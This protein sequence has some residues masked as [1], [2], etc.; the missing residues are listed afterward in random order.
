MY[1]LRN[2]KFIR[3]ILILSQEIKTISMI[4]IL[5]GIDFLERIVKEEKLKIKYGIFETCTF[6]ISMIPKFKCPYIMFN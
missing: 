1:V 3:T 2:M 5:S 6:T 4:T